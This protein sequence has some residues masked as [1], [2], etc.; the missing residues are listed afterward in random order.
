[1]SGT[2]VQAPPEQAADESVVDVALVETVLKILNQQGFSEPKQTTARNVLEV[3]DPKTLRFTNTRLG[4]VMVPQTARVRLQE[5]L[6]APNTFRGVFCRSDDESTIEFA[7]KEGADTLLTFLK[8]LSSRLFGRIPTQLTYDD[9]TTHFAAPDINESIETQIGQE[10]PCCIITDFP[11]RSDPFWNVKRIGGEPARGCF[12][13]FEL[14]AR[15]HRV[16]SSAEL[17]CNPTEMRDRF[18]NMQGG[19]FKKGVLGKLRD[20]FSARFDQYLRNKFKPI[21]GG[22][23]DIIKLANALKKKRR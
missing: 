8:T 18:E 22:T 9:V 21:S 14:F 1:M 20:E 13:Q 7:L 3:K 4:L 6:L 11:E 5:Q 10:W 23:I 19:E 16:V 12:A 17:S 15:G 2:N